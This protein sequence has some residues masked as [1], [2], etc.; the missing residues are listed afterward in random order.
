M[1]RRVFL[2]AMFLAPPHQ[3]QAYLQTLRDTGWT[4]KGEAGAD[5][6][7]VVAELFDG[8]QLRPAALAERKRRSNA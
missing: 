6:D 1:A 2:R 7:M 8:D 3:S 4:T 5:Y